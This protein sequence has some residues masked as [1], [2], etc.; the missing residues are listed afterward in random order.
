MPQFKTTRRVFHSAENMYQLVAD[1]EKYPEFVPLCDNLV[2]KSREQSGSMDIVLA[3]MTVAYKLLRETF[4]SRVS[5]NIEGCEIVS[6]GVDGPFRHLKNVWRFHEIDK[7]CCDVEFSIS[8]EFKTFAL[9]L[10]VGGLFEKV[11]KKYSDAFEER[12]N[13][14][15]GPPIREPQ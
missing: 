5:M 14:I 9:Q 6:E 10:L 12:A 2:I 1:I 15:Y 13:Q 3:D 7:T 11:F 8:Y 4:G